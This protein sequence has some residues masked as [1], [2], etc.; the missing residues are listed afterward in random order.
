MADWVEGLTLLGLRAGGAAFVLVSG[1]VLW[2]IM[3]GRMAGG[4]AVSPADR[5]RIVENVILAGRILSISGLVLIFSA[6]TRYYWEEVTGYLFL[7]GGGALY[8]GVPMLIGSSLQLVGTDYARV[9]VFVVG[10]FKLVGIMAMVFSVPFILA[11]FWLKMRGVRRAIPRSAVSVSKEPEA[12]KSRLYI[13][14]WQLPYCREYLR[15]FCNA[16]EQ[17]KSC[18]R[19]KSGCY[20]DEDMILRVMKRSSTSR[21]PGFDQ[22]YSEVAGGKKSL[23]SAQ[24]RERCRQCF[25]YA[26]HQKQKYRMLSPLV[27]PAT[28]LLMWIYLDPVRKALK[29]ALDKTDTL[30]QNLQYGPAIANQ[31]TNA[32]AT[33]ETVMWLFLMCIGLVVITYLLRGLEFMIFELQM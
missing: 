18:W 12:P 24:K 25:L 5:A 3:T 10:Q 17:R 22:R 30:A 23:T 29:F 28:M 26:E 33:S 2:G 4:E 6:A 1:Y 31:W 19:V 20:C 8:W 15:K 27:F 9:L 21:L 13:F 32:Q 7:I 14:C 11:D 16:Y